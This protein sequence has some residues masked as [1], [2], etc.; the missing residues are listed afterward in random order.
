MSSE[1]QEVKINQEPS[2]NENVIDDTDDVFDIAGR[3]K[4]KPQEE[5]VK[6]MTASVKN[7][8]SV[9]QKLEQLR[10]EK[11]E[12]ERTHQSQNQKE[13][14][15]LEALRRFKQQQEEKYIEQ[16]L[17]IFEKVKE[18]L[19]KLGLMDEKNQEQ[20]EY[21]KK[22]ITDPNGNKSSDLIINLTGKNIKL[23]E[24]NE[25][26]KRQTDQWNNIFNGM[27]AGNSLPSN[28]FQKYSNEYVAVQNNKKNARKFVDAFFTEQEE[29]HEEIQQPPCKK[30][31]VQNSSKA[32][33]NNNI[34]DNGYSELKKNYS[35]RTISNSLFGKD[36]KL[37]RE[38]MDFKHDLM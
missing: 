16:Q 15:E 33:N 12:L 24:E 20:V 36:P 11:E 10:R 17:P 3:I 8:H 6:M 22:K 31:V 34:N 2:N 14:E 38:I 4:G 35:D 25:E 13:R 5:I 30:R 23:S 21:L 27:K 7:A 18:N 29:E 37:F 19:T 9:N 28:E 26:L 1:N 32:S